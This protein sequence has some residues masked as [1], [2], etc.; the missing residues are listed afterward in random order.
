MPKVGND[1]L[2]G[3]R[4]TTFGKME[5]TPSNLLDGKKYPFEDFRS[6]FLV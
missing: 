2:G 4:C 5:I 3:H 1:D 6:S